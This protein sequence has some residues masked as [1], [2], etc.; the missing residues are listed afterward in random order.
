VSF[1]PS[2]FV[3]RPFPTPPISP[4]LTKR[5][6]QR[7]LSRPYSG[8]EFKNWP[9]P[10]FLR[11]Q[12]GNA[13]EFLSLDYPLRFPLLVRRLVEAYLNLERSGKRHG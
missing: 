12:S 2:A 11:A 4:R 3:L 5:Q 9:C 7:S 8:V 6:D 10:F 13:G 1:H